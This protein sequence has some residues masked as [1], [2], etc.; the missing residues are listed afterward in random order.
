[1]G[2][3]LPKGADFLIQTHYHRNGQP[4]R[5][6][7]QVGLYFAKGPIEQPWQTIVVNGMKP[8][9]RIRA[10]ETDHLAKGAVYLHTDAVLHNVLPHMH[11]LGKR[12]KVTMTP[13]HGQPVVLVE[14]PAWDYKWQE[15]YSFKEPIHAKAGTKLEIEAVFD[16]SASNPNNPSNPPKDV[17]VGEQ[18]TNEMLFGFFGA[19]S[20]KTPWVT[21][22]HFGLPTA[23]P[24]RRPG[25]DQGQADAGTRTLS[26]QLEL[27]LG[28]QGSRRQRD[29]D[30]R[31]R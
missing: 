11:L 9:E 25:P 7:T 16:N 10:G 23:R 18:T 21:D 1:M 17:T 13:P 5:D 29:Q 26:R 27:G 28:P 24:D 22:P 6:R 4:A 14:I 2:W 12:T 31:P 20:T 3:L 30:Q 15:T 8:T 19:T